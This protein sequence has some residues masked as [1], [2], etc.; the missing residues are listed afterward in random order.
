MFL[1]D[2]M[3]AI[4]ISHLFYSAVHSVSY[5]NSRP[6]KLCP[7]MDTR[8]AR[9]LWRWPTTF[10]LDLRSTVQEGM[11]P[12]YCN[13]ATGLLVGEHEPQG[14]TDNYYFARWASYQIAPY[15]CS[16]LSALIREAPSCNGKWPTQK[17]TGNVKR[18]NT[19]GVLNH[20]ETS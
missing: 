12:W 7:W 15:I 19:R 5:N 9:M 3:P 10:W 11:H 2:T 18:I 16:Q 14:W 1:K 6:D 13:L 4:Y 20:T 17:L 8:V